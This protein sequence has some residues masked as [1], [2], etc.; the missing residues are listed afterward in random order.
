MGYPFGD[1]NILFTHRR[2]PT[3][4]AKLGRSEQ[5]IKR[6]R[7]TEDSLIEHTVC[8]ALHQ[9]PLFGARSNPGRNQGVF[10]GWD[11]RCCPM[12]PARLSSVVGA[13]A[14]RFPK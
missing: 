4:F 7:R 10:L 11:C 8:L 2:M 3:H 14:L 1:K 12:H 5:V 6:S 13:A 9:R